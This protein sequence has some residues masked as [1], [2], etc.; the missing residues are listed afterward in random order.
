M[1]TE[2]HH[3][4]GIQFVDDWLVLEVD[5]RE[6]RFQLSEISPVLD[7]ASEAERSMFEISPS[8]YGIH[9]PQLDEDLSIDA[10]LGIVHAPKVGP[11]SV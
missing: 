7:K 10:L 9:W 1:S 8:G 5:G 11:R 3:V 6:E 2:H 4:A